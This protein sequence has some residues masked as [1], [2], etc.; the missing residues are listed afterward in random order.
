MNAWRQAVA[1]ASARRGGWQPTPAHESQAA[2]A[3]LKPAAVAKTEAHGA[4]QLPGGHALDARDRAYFERRLGADFSHVRVHTEGEAAETADSLGARALA[5]GGDI[6]FGPGEYNPRSVAGRGLL[7]HELTHTV[8]Q[9][10]AREPAVQMQGKQPAAGLGSRPPKDDFQ[11]ADKTV[12]SDDFVLFDLNQATLSAADQKKLAAAAAAHK[13]P[14]TLTIHGYASEEGGADYNVNLA[15]WRAAAVKQFLAPKLAP[16]SRIILYSNGKTTDFGPL[17]KNRRAGFTISDG[18]QDARA[19]EA[20]ELAQK[21]AADRKPGE[22]WTFD[23]T[24]GAARKPGPLDPGAHLLGPGLT[25]GLGLGIVPQFSLAPLPALKPPVG[26]DWSAIRPKFSIHGV[27]PDDRDFNAI[28]QHWN[29]SY[30]FLFGI[31]HDPALAAKGANLAVPYAVNKWLT[32]EHPNSM[33]TAQQRFEQ[34]Y[35]GITTY[36]IP[37]SDIVDGALQHFLKTKPIFEF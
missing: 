3:T 28:E 16:T 7:A 18:V 11:V 5:V 12:N 32:L 34:A 6:A 23:I 14:V 10:Q 27:V 36:N 9:A 31:L 35:G 33:D 22:P 30:N 4:A 17:E 8:Q 25:P 1:S 19:V 20:K 24:G 37:L 26:I 13:G 15:A 29:Y 21:D 2:S